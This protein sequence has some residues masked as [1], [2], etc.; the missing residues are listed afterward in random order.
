MCISSLSPK[1]ISS[2]SFP[3]VI[4]EIYHCSLKWYFTENVRMGNK[5][6]SCEEKEDT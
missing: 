1:Y 4:K 3:I 6:V 5:L 2:R